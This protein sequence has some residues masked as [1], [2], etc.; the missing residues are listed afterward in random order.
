MSNFE[1]C[2]LLSMNLLS[3]R[4]HQFAYI[5][6]ICFYSFCHLCDSARS[7]RWK[8]LVSISGNFQWRMEQHLSQFPVKRTTLLGIP[9]V[10]EISYGEF[11]FPFNFLPEFPEFS[12]EWFEFR[13]LNDFWISWK[14]PGKFQYPLSSFWSFGIIGWIESVLR[15]GNSCNPRLENTLTRALLVSAFSAW[16]VRSKT[17]AVFSTICWRWISAGSLPSL[18]SSSTGF[19]TLAI[20]SPCRVTAIDCTW[21]KELLTLSIKHDRFF[22]LHLKAQVFMILTSPE[23]AIW[24]ITRR[25]FAKS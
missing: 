11:S 2:F 12:F 1:S 14:D 19:W 3:D 7:V 25:R 8:M 15:P 21:N 13:K 5:F 23:F 10:S 17:S 20:R 16:N 18:L 4:K 6:E 22:L 9:R 24:R